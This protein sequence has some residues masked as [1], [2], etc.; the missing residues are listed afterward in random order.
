VVPEAV[1]RVYSPLGKD[2]E[3]GHLEEQSR[4]VEIVIGVPS[5][6]AATD[7]EL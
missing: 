2:A 6:T 5:T 4:T 3:M 7:A 1:A